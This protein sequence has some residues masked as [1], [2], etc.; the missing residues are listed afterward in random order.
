LL[1]VIS[2]EM[3]SMGLLDPDS[4]TDIYCLHLTVSHLLATATA[5]WME[6]W[7]HHK[8]STAS[9]KTPIQLFVE[10]IR[11]LEMASEDFGG[12][13]PRELDQVFI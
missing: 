13:V 3:E 7:N 9:N 8:I 12:E 5:T 6:T 4:D 10:G 1:F 11:E 2:S